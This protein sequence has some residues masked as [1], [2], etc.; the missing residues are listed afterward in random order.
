[1]RLRTMVAMIALGLAISG[2]GQPALSVRAQLEAAVR[3]RITAAAVLIVVAVEN[4]YATGSGTVVAASGLI[5][6]NQH[7]IAEADRNDIPIGVFQ[8]NGRSEPSLT[9][10]AEVVT[11][12]AALDLAVLQVVA[13]PEGIPV[14]PDQL[15]LPY[16]TLGDSELLNLGDDLYIVGY[17]GINQSSLT[18]TEGVVSGFQ[19]EPGIE[20][21]AWIVTDAVISGG[22]SG[23]TATNAAGELVGI[24]TMG[25]PLDC[26]PGDT[27]NDGVIDGRD[28]CRA[29]GGS[30]A[31]LR[32]SNLA[33][34]LLSTAGPGGSGQPSGPAATA[35]APTSIPAP[36]VQPPPDQAARPPLIISSLLPEL[37]T[38]SSG[39]HF[40][41]YDL[42]A[43][44][45]PELASSFSAPGRAR[46]M[47][48]SYGWQENAYRIFAAD[49]P[50]PNAA[51]WI[52]MSIH[53]FASVD[54]AHA[55]LSYLAGERQTGLGL[56]FFDH[57]L[58]ADQS[59]ALVGPAFNGTET[60]F[61]ARRGNLVVRVT[62]IAPNGDP[63]DHVIEA[64]LI[65]L[66]PLAEDPR[67][68]S[69]DLL[70][71]LPGTDN[72]SPELT[73]TEERARSASNTAETFV[74]PD[75]TRELFREWGWRESASR[76]YSSGAGA[77]ANGTTRLESVVYRWQDAA[78]A[79]AA[80]SY[81]A[82][83]R[84]EALD[85]SG[86]AVLR[87][88]DES[89][90]IVGPVSGGLEATVY[91]RSG[92]FLYRFT[93]IGPGNPMADLRSLLNIP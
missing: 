74:N 60:T 79:S 22:S 30:V 66:V 17:P 62:G 77:T 4:G 80:L 27:N 86:G 63:T 82:T 34:P 85:L 89:R 83:S 43:A 7:V 29:T 44:T 12:D 42:G 16:L 47:L 61:F 15:N 40:R 38:L 54:G 21:D 19:T 18:Y 56:D 71:L 75:Q 53:Q 52:E 14:A 26:R 20:G 48:T 10:W 92:S 67:V 37:L 84:A 93:M 57:E 28:G 5:L 90:T 35:P 49:N 36:P 51:G 88:G 3:D 87:I 23:G 72:I 2:S 13:D 45:L 25:R 33:K 70:A 11:A 6:T 41:L 65:P 69:P 1:M 91:V 58:F 50:P 32:P 78:G 31:Y 76:V 68:V 73:L 64:M 81:F 9:Y 24:P 59:L 39:Q 55:A 46:Q 8:S